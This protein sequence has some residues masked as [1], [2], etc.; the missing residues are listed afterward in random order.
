MLTDTVSTSCHRVPHGENITGGVFVPIVGSAARACPFTDAQRHLFLQRAALAA[1]FAAREPAVDFDHGLSVHGGFGLNHPDG[2]TDS[3]IAQAAGELVVFKHPAQ[4]QIFDADHVESGNKAPRQ[5][6]GGVLAG[7]GDLFMQHSNPLFL[8]LVAVRS[9]HLAGQR[10]LLA[11]HAPLVAVQVLRVGDPLAG[12]QRGQAADAEVNADGLPGFWQRRGLYINHQR[13]EIFSAW[14]ADDGYR[15]R[16]NRD[17]FGPLDLQR[18]EL[19]DQQPLIPKLEL[20]GRSGVFRRLLAILT[21]E[22]RVSG[23]LLEEVGERC[24]QIAQ[25]LLSRDTGDIVQP[26]RFWLLLELCQRR[27]GLRIIHPLAALERFGPLIK[28]PVVDKPNAAERLGKRFGLLI[29]G[30]ASECPSLF[31]VLHASIVSCKLQHGR[32]LSL[33]GLNPGASRG[34]KG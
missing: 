19:R 28:A 17:V 15:G 34:E 30:V 9:L 3:G 29:G 31:H 10:L 11:L 14:L 2:V 25:R 18:A 22:G 26:S 5:L 24:L 33:P 16:I 27:A 6:G 21:L 32:T 4:V 7:V 12:A 23:A 8:P 20:E 13:D 1:H